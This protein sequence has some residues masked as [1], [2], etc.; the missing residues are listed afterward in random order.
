MIRY[1]LALTGA[2]MALVL[3]SAPTSAES[4]SRVELSKM[5]TGVAPEDFTISRTGKGA[6]A[7]W[8]VVDDPTGQSL[9]PTADHDGAT[10]L[11]AGIGLLPCPLTISVLGFAWAQGTAIMIGLVLVALALGIATTIGLV[12]VA[13][14]I[15]RHTLGVVLLDRLPQLERASRVLQGVAGAGIVAIGVCTIIVVAR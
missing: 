11:T 13:A 14:I 3:L 7:Q 8:V 5:Q 1:M 9:R 15:G 4:R 2:G 10:T 6:P 12:A